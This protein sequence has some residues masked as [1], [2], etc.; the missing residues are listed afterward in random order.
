MQNGKTAIQ[1]RFMHQIPFCFDL[2]P[3]NAT[4]TTRLFFA[5]GLAKLVLLL[6]GGL[7]FV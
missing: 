3:N 2:F 7:F 4:I 6:F 5:V 1:P